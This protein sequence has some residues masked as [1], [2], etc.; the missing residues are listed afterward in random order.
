MQRL[1]LF[2]LLCLSF[3][4]VS[5]QT[6]FQQQV[7]AAFYPI[8]KLEPAAQCEAFRGLQQR[9][10]DNGLTKD[11]TYSNLLFLYAGA[12][13]ANDQAS[14]AIIL[15]N[16]AIRVAERYPELNPSHYLAKYY[17]Y[18]GYYLSQNNAHDLALISYQRCLQISKTAADKW[19]IRELACEA[20]AH[21]YYQIQDYQTGLQYAELGCKYSLARGNHAALSRNMYEKCV[22]LNALGRLGE[23]S[24]GMI[25]LM[26]IN[27]EQTGHVELASYY[28]LAGDISLNQELHLQAQKWY[29]KA[30]SLYFKNELYE[31]L[32]GIYLDL[33]FT[34]ILMK[35]QK[36]KV[37]YQLLAQRYIKNPYYLS[38]LHNNMALDKASNDMYEASFSLLN[39]A[40]ID[41]PISFKPK[42]IFENPTLESL[43]NLSEKD[44][45]LT[46]LL[47]K[48]SLLLKSQTN[49]PKALQ[50]FDLLDSLTD[51]IRWEHQGSV[52][53]LFWRS[54]MI[55][56]YEDAI[57]TSFLLNRTDRAFYF[58][59][60]SHSALLNDELNNLQAA[61]MLPTLKVWEEEQ[62]RLRLRS[63]QLA[64]PHNP[65]LLTSAH[66]KLK[67]FVKTLEHQ[68][69][70][71][72]YFKYY[73]AVPVIKEIQNYLGISQQTLISYFVGEDAVYFIA[74]G[75]KTLERKKINA[76]TFRLLTKQ[77][78]F[79]ISNK[80]LQNRDYRG[81]LKVSNSLYNL[82]FKPLAMKMNDRI[83]I[84]TESAPLPFAALSRSAEK[85]DY[86]V[87][88]YAFSYINSA[89]SLF[90][91]FPH[92]DEAEIKGDFL[93][94][95]PVSFNYSKTLSPLPYSTEAI[96][97]NAKSFE[98]SKIMSAEQATS[99][100]FLSNWQKYRV[101]QVITH[102]Y[103]DSL[104]DQTKLYFADASL[105]LSGIVGLSPSAT[106]IMMLTACQSGIGTNHI[107]EGV[108]SLSRAFLA[109]GTPSVISALWEIED[110]DAY[111]LS[112]VIWEGV[113]RGLPIDLALQNAQIEWLNNDANVGSLPYSWAGVVLIGDSR[114][115]IIRR[116]N[117]GVIIVSS[118][119][120]LIVLILLGYYKVK[121]SPT[122]S[123]KRFFFR[124]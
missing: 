16:Q 32:G 65:E 59:E 103:V 45:V 3:V 71:Y 91:K 95:A 69:P 53:Q 57:E 92:L 47:D 110:Q 94:V 115:E 85:E 8:V 84:S 83:I 108:Y 22:N 122:T 26:S 29:L 80:Q 34:A 121:R 118:T 68:Y 93:G 86:M 77:L 120:I 15:V 30:S 39:Q 9:C 41:L 10:I 111:E 82:L 113:G 13:F 79:Y 50:T 23:A 33:H 72:F 96:R 19:G 40:L 27:D 14:T 114:N 100:N 35:D 88:H 97:E 56:M 48:A 117:N 104:E 12:E 61:N 4:P 6:N 78:G 31:E 51:L 89:K 52:I 43:E 49:L 124:Q 62:L 11:T 90:R 1:Q 24:K 58:M 76:N 75:P 98:S 73:N 99:H 5:A 36:A 116:H 67:L 21:S 28:K 119:L 123:L 66:Q 46:V 20:I 17:Y 63:A 18:A 70:Q 112:R 109:L 81:Y 60:K 38:R 37:Q 44:Y 74:I 105:G 87:R 7:W 55:K 25:E 42:D 107:G 64:K 101:V 2:V 102:A 54:K 106:K